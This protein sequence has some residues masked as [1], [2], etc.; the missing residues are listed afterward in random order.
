MFGLQTCFI[1]TLTAP[2]AVKTPESVYTW[3]VLRKTGFLR[4]FDLMPLGS[5]FY[6]FLFPPMSL[7][8]YL[9]RILPLSPFLFLSIS[10]LRKHTR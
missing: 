7:S 10:T 8:H 3:L 6:G 9:P 2:L 5:C 1:C 4:K